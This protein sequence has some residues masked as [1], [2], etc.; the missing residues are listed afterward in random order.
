MHAYSPTANA[1]RPIHRLTSVTL[2]DLELVGLICGARIEGLHFDIVEGARFERNEDGLARRVGRR[3][4][5]DLL[6]IR[7]GKVEVQVVLDIVP[8]ERDAVL[9]NASG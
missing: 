9:T 8:G 2:R 6:V 3:R 4:L 7:V 1:P 5:S